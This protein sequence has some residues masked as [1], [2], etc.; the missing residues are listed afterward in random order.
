LLCV[1]AAGRHV[2]RPLDRGAAR[3]LQLPPGVKPLR[4]SSDGRALIILTADGARGGRISRLDLE[5]G[6]ETLLSKLSTTGDLHMSS[7]LVSADGRGVAYP[8]D[9]RE[10]SLFR[11]G[12]L[13]P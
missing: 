4:F 7:P 13:G 3:P 12:G 8:G 2:L 11:V 10:S 5:T 6:A 9:R 1:D